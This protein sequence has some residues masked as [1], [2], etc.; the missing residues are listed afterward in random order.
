MPACLEKTKRRPAI[1]LIWLGPRARRGPPPPG[2]LAALQADHP[3]AV[4][5]LLTHGAAGLPGQ[6]QAFRAGQIWPDGAVTSPARLLALLR[7]LSWAQ[8]DHVY[9][10]APCLRTRIYRYLTRPQPIWHIGSPALPQ[11]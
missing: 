10:L 5:T 7:R 8:F 6:E 2:L 4:F 3:E 9:D 1:L 11:D